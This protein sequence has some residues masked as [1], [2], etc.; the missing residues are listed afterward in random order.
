MNSSKAFPLDVVP[1]ET[2]EPA[3]LEGLRGAIAAEARLLGDLIAVM[4]SQRSCVASEDF[5]G[6]DDSVF[7]T[8]RIL[9]TLAEARRHRRSLIR[10]MGAGDDL[11]LQHLEELLGAQLTESIRGVR[12]DLLAAAGTLSCEVEMNRKV[13]R[14]LL[15]GDPDR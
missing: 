4:R 2:I 14:R 15:S 3:R 12:G 7:A 13:L 5:Q 6:V 9:A 11:H 8:H 1:A 10:L